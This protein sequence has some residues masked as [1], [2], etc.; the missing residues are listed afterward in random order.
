M[1]GVPLFQIDPKVAFPRRT[2]PKVR[3]LISSYRHRYVELYVVIIIR[4]APPFVHTYV[5]CYVLLNNRLPVQ[6]NKYQSQ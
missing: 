1:F 2:H 6:D 5:I 3:K 4:I